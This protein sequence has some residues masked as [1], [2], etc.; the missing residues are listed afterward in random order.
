MLCAQCCER[1]ACTHA[2]PWL[3]GILQPLPA[4]LTAMGCMGANAAFT[5][6]VLPE[7]LT[8]AARRLVRTPVPAPAMPSLRDVQTLYP[9]LD[10]LYGA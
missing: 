4:V 8:P 9:V 5:A 10:C 1:S 7:S 3:G 6:L 2:G